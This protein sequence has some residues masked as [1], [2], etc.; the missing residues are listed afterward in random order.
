MGCD[1]NC[2]SFIEFHQIGDD[3]LLIVG[4][5]GRSGLVKK[6]ILGVLVYGSSDEIVNAGAALAFRSRMS[7]LPHFC[8]FF[9]VQVD[10]VENFNNFVFGDR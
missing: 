8:K 10:D 2:T 1:D 4:I 5:Q 3:H 6:N 7:I 9:V